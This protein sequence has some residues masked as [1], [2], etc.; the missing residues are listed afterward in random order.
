MA[1]TA[2]AS[3]TATS[4]GRGIH[5]DFGPVLLQNTIVAYNGATNCNTGLTSNDYNLDS[6]NTCG[7]SA[8]HD[9]P[10]TDPLLGPLA[11][12]GGD[13]LTHALLEASPAIKCG[14][15]RSRHHHQPARRVPATGRHMRHW[16]L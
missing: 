8:L 15:L 4:G 14:C 13:T 7:F 10:N 3:N 5:M 11:D 9:Q 1:S 2:V 12:N 16:R 6:G